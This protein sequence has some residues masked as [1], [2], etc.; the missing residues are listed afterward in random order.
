MSIQKKFQLFLVCISYLE[1][2]SNLSLS[3]PRLPFYWTPLFFVILGYFLFCHPRT[4]V[5]RSGDLWIAGSSPAMTR[6]NE[7]PAMTMEKNV[8][9]SDTLR[10][11]RRP[12]FCACGAILFSA[13]TFFRNQKFPLLRSGN[14]AFAPT[15][16]IDSFFKASPASGAALKDKGLKLKSEHRKNITVNA[17]LSGAVQTAATKY[18]IPRAVV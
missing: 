11:E 6:E 1:M 14:S 16:Q 13:Y 3:A 15:A 12:F 18:R 9:P 5:A 4:S 10:K 7:N 2:S 8:K 17:A